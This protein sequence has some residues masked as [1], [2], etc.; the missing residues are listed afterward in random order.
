MNNQQ[1]LYDTMKILYYDFN[2]SDL[3]IKENQSFFLNISSRL[4]STLV[5]YS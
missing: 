5:H 1:M 2:L 4:K 3:R